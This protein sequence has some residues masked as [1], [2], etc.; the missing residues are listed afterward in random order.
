MDRHGALSCIRPSDSVH[1]SPPSLRL[2]GS[3]KSA[4]CFNRAK[5]YKT[6]GLF[7][8]DFAVRD[9]RIYAETLGGEVRHYRDSNGLE[10]D[11]VLHLDD[12]RWAPV[13]IKLGGE[14]GIFEGIKNLIKLED[15]LSLEYPKPAFKMVLTAGGR[16]YMTP[17]GIAVA[18]IN[19]LGV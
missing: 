15:G 3:V 18:P 2:C 6:S 5:D 12:G 7:F 13:E 10:C 9:L 4:T 16:A 14:K 11:A 8:E 17:E 19:K 1:A